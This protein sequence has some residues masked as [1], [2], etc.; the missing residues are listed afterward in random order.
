MDP[1]NRAMLPG[2][3]DPAA[4][5]TVRPAG[6]ADRLAWDRFVA[7]A[8]Q[9]I[10]MQ[11]WGWGDLR[12]RSGWRV[13]R[14]I[15]ER[16]GSWRA[17]IQ[18]LHRNLLP[19]GLGWAYAPR[20][21][22]LP[23][24]ADLPAAELLLARARIELLRRRVLLLRLDPEWDLDSEAAWR[25]RLK[26]RPARFDIQHSQTWLVPLGA[27]AA[28]TLA[29]LPAS[30]RRNIH[31][32]ERSEVTVAVGQEPED[33]ARFYA[34]HL[35][36]VRRQRFQTRPLAYYQAVIEELGARV[37]LASANG[38]PLAAAIGVACGPRLIY[39]YGGTSTA[40]PEVRASY[41]L[42]WAM[43]RWGIE[44]G[45]TEYDMWGV[46]RHFVPGDPAPGYAVFKTRWGGRLASHSGLLVAPMLGPL[47]PAGHRL[48]AWLLRRRP[49]LT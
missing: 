28:D 14:L 30:T 15:A 25:R 1:H 43:I 31:I 20:G 9:G 18:I 12:R 34:L 40:R 38:L 19:G 7:G 36:T 23:S 37:F 16:D 4:E 33:V 39:L 11:T 35:E 45:C 8:C 32:S 41:A 13:L 27:T 29:A 48:E 22:A 5:L 2:R 10:L 42:H 44:R 21:P 6:P 26:L 49:L 3:V 46:P 24:P 17:A 47:D